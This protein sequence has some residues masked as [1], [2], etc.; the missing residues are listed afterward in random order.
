M[1]CGNPFLF[2]Q[3]CLAQDLARFFLQAATVH[4]G[5][6]LEFLNQFFLYIT[7]QKVVQSLPPMCLHLH[8]RRT[9]KELRCIGG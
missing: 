5:A 6:T 8:F 3:E 1:G 7:D 9:A 2:I 4:L